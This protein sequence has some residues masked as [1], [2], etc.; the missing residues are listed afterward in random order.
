MKALSIMRFTLWITVV[1]S[2]GVLTANAQL[3]SGNYLGMSAEEQTAFVD[4]Q[5]RR[6]AREAFGAEYEFT[7]EFTSLIQKSVDSYAKR[8]GKDLLGKNDPLFILER[9]RV[10]APR[11]AAT[12]KSRN[13]SPIIGLYIP[14]I[15][16]AYVNLESPNQVGAI[17]LFQFM[18][19]TGM[20]YGLTPEELLD[21][22]KSADA[23]AR[24]ILDSLQLFEGDS[25]KEALA[26]LSYNRGGQKVVQ[27]LQLALTDQNRRCSICAL[28]AASD[29]LDQ[30]F[31]NE[32]VYYVPSFF[33]AAIV[34]ENPRAFGLKSRPL[35]SY[36]D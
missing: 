11:I 7:P 13:V 27:D 22:D 17:G 12:F 1:M 19:K 18:P 3:K 10:Y 24:Y 14:F 23:A 35:S 21:V 4:Q 33:A 15:E 8:M 16:S 32:S 2:C 6:I 28:T 30:N 26:L 29:R 20:R 9:G 36:A 31:Q 34:G 25:M 5:A